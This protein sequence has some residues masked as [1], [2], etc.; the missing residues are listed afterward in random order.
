MAGERAESQR[1]PLPPI[2]FFLALARAVR[3]GRSWCG[4]ARLREGEAQC[5]EN[6][7]LL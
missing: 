4:G 1:T 5:E 3:R 2:F 7:G 6:N